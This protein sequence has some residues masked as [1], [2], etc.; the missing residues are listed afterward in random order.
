METSTFEEIQ[1]STASMRILIIDDYEEIRELLIEDLKECGFSGDTM[2]ASDFEE[3]R[4]ILN[5]YPIDHIILDIHLPKH[6]GF[7]ILNGLKKNPKFNHIPVTMLSADSDVSII[8]EALEQGAKDFLVKPW[9]LDEIK[10]R[11]LSSFNHT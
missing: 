9:S 11:F 8:L 4:F 6:H 7:S 5:K 3:A 10:K 1:K 2:Q